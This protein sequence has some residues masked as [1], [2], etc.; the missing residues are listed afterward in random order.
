MLKTT[1][2]GNYPKISS[3]KTGPNLRNAL[4]LKD[5]G[6]IRAENLEEVYQET[7]KRVIREQE[8]AGIDI[9][10]DG[11]IR[12]DDLVTPVAR[13]I[14]GIEIGGLI[15]FFDNNV[16]YRRPIINSQVSFKN[17]AT[18]EQ[19]KFAQAN[20][21]KP[22]KAVLP[23]PFTLAKLCSDQYYNNIDKLTL[24]LAEILN[25]EAKELEKAGAKFI[26]L[27]EPSLCYNPDKVDLAIKAIEKA[28]ENIS[29][30]KILFFYFGNVKSLF[31]RILD[32]SVDV[33]GV[34]VVSKP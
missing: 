21:K 28:F 23:G 30:K 18:V 33:I 32:T 25:Q 26:Q 10:T 4:N 14:Q 15:R 17:L 29:V 12:W 6:K 7:I 19:F 8:E 34:D 27:D 31:P 24:G 5:Q 11:Q 16:Y 3:E 13:N 22:V 20:A 9:I 1:V 2:V